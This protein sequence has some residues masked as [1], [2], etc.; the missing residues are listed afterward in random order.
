MRGRYPILNQQRTG[1]TS[2]NSRL[3][4]KQA[5]WS[6]K[7]D[8]CKQM[9]AFDLSIWIVLT[10]RSCKISRCA[11]MRDIAKIAKNRWRAWVTHHFCDHQL[12]RYATLSQLTVSFAIFRDI[13]R[14]CASRK[15]RENRQRAW[16]THQFWGQQMKRYASLSSRLS[17]YCNQAGMFVL[18]V[19][20]V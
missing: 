10:V 19:G 6:W 13:A 7:V 1:L 17:L 20:H 3:A 4:W 12:K 14:G 18:E 16:V 8:N 2:L 9:G 5:C 15:N 11:C